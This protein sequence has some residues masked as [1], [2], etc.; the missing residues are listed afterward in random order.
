MDGTHKMLRS[1]WHLFPSSDG[2]WMLLAPDERLI[3]L[4]I[5]PDQAE[6][7][8]RHL[9]GEALPEQD[10]LRPLLDTFAR[11]GLL[12]P[13]D[14]SR[15]DL[16]SRRV[17]IRGDGPIAAAVVRLLREA[18]IG[19][20]DTESSDASE[21]PDLIIACGGWL[22][23]SDWLRLDA[24]CR[25]RNVAWTS[26]HAEGLRFYAGPLTIPGR[27]AG[28]ADVRARR[29]AAARFPDE[30]GALWRHLDRGR[31]LPPVPWPN[32]AGVTALAA[33][34]VSDPLAWLAGEPPPHEGEQICFDP[35]DFS[36]HGH[37]VLPVPRDL[38][39]EA[40]A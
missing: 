13:R 9:G 33:L 31:N 22:P 12:E 7:L 10:D 30:L 28:Y 35:V 38:M 16:K 4:R 27:T 5:E 39:L 24:W 23:D 6:R 15:P 36:W 18:G 26:C 19:S 17:V 34:L 11:Q 1:G 20:V 25:E 14:R 40:V 29:L 2:S 21:L 8:A 3:R 37:P 32:A